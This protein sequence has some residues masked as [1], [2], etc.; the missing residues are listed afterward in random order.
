M[1][2]AKGKVPVPK[3]SLENLV[4]AAHNP[5][6]FICKFKDCIALYDD[7][8]MQ[9]GL[10]LCDDHN[11]EHGGGHT[12][13]GLTQEQV[14]DPDVDFTFAHLCPNTA[15]PLKRFEAPFYLVCRFYDCE[16]KLNP[17]E[18][19][20][21]EICKRQLCRF[22]INNHAGSFNCSLQ[23]SL[24]SIP[25]SRTHLQPENDSV[26]SLFNSVSREKYLKNCSYSISISNVF[27]AQKPITANSV[28]IGMS[29]FP[30][31][32]TFKIVSEL[33]SDIGCTAHILNVF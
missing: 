13:E 19:R 31:L 11:E 10:E 23:D 30:L 21:C 24:H 33:Q 16:E 25:P 28:E 1:V 29:G 6:R 27:L 20:F 26:D 2:S 22:H 3:H 32:L 17:S 9:C 5:S 18:D 15:S 8:C 4:P 12:P 14:D 7:R